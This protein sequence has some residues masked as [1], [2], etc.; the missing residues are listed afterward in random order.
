MRGSKNRS[1]S[2][3]PSNAFSP[4]FLRRISRREEPLTA[5][6]ADAAG[7]WVIEKIPL[8][9]FGVNRAGA[10]LSR[11]YQPAAMFTDRWLAL[12]AAAV[13]PSI[14][15]D[16]LLS[17]R[18]EGDDE[19]VYYSVVLDDGTLVGSLGDFNEDL[20][21]AMNTAINLL[22]SPESLARLLE[23]AGSVTLDRCGAILDW[24]VSQASEEGEVEK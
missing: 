11:G 8:F 13:L 12:I 1:T 14:G 6:E 5:A 24:Q 16:L 9:G 3:L 4:S 10:G 7:P 20:L 21:R 17:L 15:K 2:S 19:T 22:R 23:A 18:K